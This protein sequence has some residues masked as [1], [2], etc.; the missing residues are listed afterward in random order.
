MSGRK[1][2]SIAVLK[3]NPQDHDIDTAEM[4][5]LLRNERFRQRQESVS[6]DRSLVSS[7]HLSDGGLDDRS[8]PPDGT[9]F[10]PIRQNESE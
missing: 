1:L 10:T 3:S 6:K 2:E 8:W 4:P 7:G 9:R 5:D